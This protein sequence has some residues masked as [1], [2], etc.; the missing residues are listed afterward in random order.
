[1]GSMS[2]DSL[3]QTQDKGPGRTATPPEVVEKI[4]HEYVEMGKRWE[5]LA[6]ENDLSYNTVRTITKGLQRGKSAA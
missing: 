4:K 6:H 2:E 1:M 3:L 5:T